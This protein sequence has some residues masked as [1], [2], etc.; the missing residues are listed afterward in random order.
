MC[1]SEA[2]LP[3][4]SRSTAAF[5]KVKTERRVVA[6]ESVTTPSGSHDALL[7]EQMDR[8]TI[9]GSEPTEREFK[10]RLWYVPGIGV[11]KTQFQRLNGKVVGTIEM[12]SF[13]DGEA[14]VE[15]ETSAATDE[16]E[17]AE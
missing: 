2:V 8:T 9:H 12:T 10:E 15:V 11:V 5:T 13:K 16:P 4:T 6:Q 14:P 3:G 7:I 17:A 1:P